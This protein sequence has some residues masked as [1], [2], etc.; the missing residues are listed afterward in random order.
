MGFVIIA[1]PTII[2]AALVSWVVTDY[3]VNQKLQEVGKNNSALMIKQIEL[4]RKNIQDQQE[5]L[6]QTK[7]ALDNLNNKIRKRNSIEKILHIVELALTRHFAAIFKNILSGHI[8]TSFLN[9]V[10]VKNFTSRLDKINKK[11]Q[12][13]FGLPKLNV[14]ELIEISKIY[15][16]KNDMHVKMIIKIPILNL[17]NYI[18]W[19]Y[20]PLPYKGD[21]SVKIFKLDSKYVIENNDYNKIRII[22]GKSLKKCMKATMLTICNSITLESTEKADICIESLAKNI[23]TKC[24]N[25]TLKTRNHCIDTSD[26]SIYCFIVKPIILKITCLDNNRIF[27]LSE[28]KEIALDNHCELYKVS[29]Q[30]LDE[31][32]LFNKIEINY[33]YTRP[34]LSIYDEVAQNYT[35]IFMIDRFKVQ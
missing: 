23:Y 7:E 8:K 18:L 10:D 29:E 25:I 31:T 12:P 19:K 3:R 22:H 11:L 34:N 1:I 32:H 6:Q 24:E 16:E 4:A 33:E 27:N 26:F 17:K 5:I 2:V 14:M 21:Q 9:I 30:K 28:S 35:E 15:H 20:I 13:D